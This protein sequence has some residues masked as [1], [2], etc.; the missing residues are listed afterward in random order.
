MFVYL[1]DFVLGAFVGLFALAAFSPVYLARRVYTL[2]WCI[3]VLF[4]LMAY[5]GK[6]SGPAPFIAANQ[7]DTSTLILVVLLGVGASIGGG[8]TWMSSQKNPSN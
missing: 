8:F 5:M 3:G 1:T 6:G 7:P 4:V 2:S